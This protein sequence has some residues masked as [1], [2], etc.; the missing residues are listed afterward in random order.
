MDDIIENPHKYHIFEGLSTLTN[1]SRYDLPDSDV[2]RDFFKVHKLYEF[3]NLAS[4]CSFFRGCP[5]DKLDVAISYELPE[6]IG[7]YKKRLQSING[8]TKSKGT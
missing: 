5:I 6:L 3:Q 1:I 2:Y 8:K 7:K 4:T